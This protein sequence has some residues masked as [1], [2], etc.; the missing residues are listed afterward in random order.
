MYGYEIGE[1]SNQSFLRSE[2]DLRYK[3]FDKNYL[4]VIANYARVEDDVFRRGE[5]FKDTKSGYAIGYGLE[6]ILGP[7]E[8]KYSW[9][10]DTKKNFLLFN[11]GFWF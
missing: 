9:S 2:F 7:I 1:L 4:T 8:I 5:L 3:L 11:L 6:T 10:P